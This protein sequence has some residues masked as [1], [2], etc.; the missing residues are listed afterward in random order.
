MD[1]NTINLR[2]QDGSLLDLTKRIL[3]VEST[4]NSP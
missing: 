2:T 4:L 1:A 3:A